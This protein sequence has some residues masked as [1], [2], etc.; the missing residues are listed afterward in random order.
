MKLFTQRRFGAFRKGALQYLIL[1]SLSQKPM[2]GYEIMRSLSEDFGGFYRPSAGATYPILQTLED[3]GYITGK[4][5]ED[6]RVYSI[7]PKGTN[8]LSENEE[9]FKGMIEKR[10]EFLEERKGL[11]RELRNLVNLIMTNYRDL[12]PDK[13]EKISQI[14]KETRRKID[15]LISE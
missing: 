2:H 9:K 14:I 1:Q 11:N 8:F 15:D 13:A 12:S 4:D 7:T 5:E 3:E 10:K 6:K